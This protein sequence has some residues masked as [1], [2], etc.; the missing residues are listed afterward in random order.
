[1][2]EEAQNVTHNGFSAVLQS[3]GDLTTA[4]MAI[5]SELTD[6][7]AQVFN[8]TAAALTQVAFA[9]TI[10]DVVE[11]QSEYTKKTYYEHLAELSKLY[12]MCRLVDVHGRVEQQTSTW[13]EVESSLPGRSILIRL[14]NLKWAD[15]SV[16]RS[17]EF[18]A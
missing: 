8:N 17:R 4:W 7:S 11:I 13:R 15:S 16:V 12:Q 2:A 5:A 3:W 14:V 10:K 18:A 9:S 1:M 6:Y